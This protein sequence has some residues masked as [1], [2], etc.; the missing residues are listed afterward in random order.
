MG[1]SRGTDGSS[2]AVELGLLDG[3]R[4]TCRPD[5]RLCCFAEPAASG[6]ERRVLVQIEPEL[7]W[8]E[9]DALLSRIAARPDGGACQLLEAARC[10]AH[11][12]RP[13]PCRAYPVHVHVGDRAQA[14]LVLS[15]PGVGLEPL[16]ASP[17]ATRAAPP[18]GLDSEIAAVREEARA[19]P[20]DELLR[21][22][23]RL[24]DR[25]L[26]QSGLDREEL[27][28]AR[29][30]STDLRLPP[31]AE[32]GLA[33]PGPEE[34]LEELPLLWAGSRGVLLLCRHE[35]GSYEP[36]RPRESGG[37]AERLGRFLPPEPPAALDARARGVVD[38]YLRFLLRRDQF[39]WS[40]VHEYDPETEADFEGALR[41]TLAEVRLE[42]L[43]RGSVLAR[44]DGGT[45]ERLGVADVE[46]GIRAIDSD[47]LDRPGPGLQL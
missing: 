6:A 28:E 4:F 47:L 13:Y 5:C 9:E 37:V 46:R 31:L 26:R 25:A 15:C 39:L 8:R 22:A 36:L 34:P 19:A 12:A 45:G 38:G 42:L 3:F 24:L 20:I 44:L 43:A 16:A 32:S 40:V 18:W 11:Y 41:R 27:E 23:S 35:D 10:R 1:A 14:S 29:R 7:E 2:G 17:P 33:P 30:R 21:R